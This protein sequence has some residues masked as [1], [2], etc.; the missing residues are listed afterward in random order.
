M[1]HVGCD[2]THH[3]DVI[4]ATKTRP[5]TEGEL[6]LSHLLILTT[7][8]PLPRACEDGSRSRG[9]QRC[10]GECGGLGVPVRLGK[11]LY[12]RWQARRKQEAP[13]TLVS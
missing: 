6:R 3:D 5:S 9:V 11:A 12:M 8:T 1:R 7:L 13:A 10:P 2:V 4:V